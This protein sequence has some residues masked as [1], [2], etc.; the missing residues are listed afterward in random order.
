VLPEIEGI[1]KGIKKEDMSNLEIPE[2]SFAS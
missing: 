2:E 1:V